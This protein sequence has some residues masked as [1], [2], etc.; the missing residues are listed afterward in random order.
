MAYYRNKTYVAFDGDNDIHYYYM[1]QAWK[2]NDH[3]GFNFHDAHEIRRSR[4][5][6][7]E[8]TIKRNLRERLKN[9]K[10]FVCLIGEQTRHLFR[11]VR[12]EI[13]LAIELEIPRIGCNLNGLRHLDDYRCPPILRETLCIHVPYQ[14]RI[15]QHAMNH[16]ADEAVRIRG[17]GGIGAYF[18]NEEVYQKL[19]L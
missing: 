16:W 14:Q 9:S 10:M 6:S 7:S 2:R 3:T 18:Y 19:G 17:Q 5:T 1:M 13:E 12:W 8:D 11:F 15:M 4:D